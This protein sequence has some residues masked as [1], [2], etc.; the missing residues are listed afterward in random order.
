MGRAAGICR[1]AN[2][3]VD[4]MAPRD[5]EKLLRGRAQQHLVLEA[6][7]HEVIKLIHRRLVET[8]DRRVCQLRIELHVSAVACGSEVLRE[9][10][11]SILHG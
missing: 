3:Q 9:Y 8:H 11:G 2:L 10:C 6:H 5:V 7:G 4:Q 1:P